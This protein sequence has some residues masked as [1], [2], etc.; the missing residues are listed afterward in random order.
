MGLFKHFKIDEFDCS[1]CGKNWVNPAL[2]KELDKVRTELGLPIKVVSGYRCP[3]H[4]KAV[5]G[6]KDSQHVLGQ[7]ADIT[8]S[9]LEKLWEILPKYFQAIGDGRAK[10]FIH[11]DRR[12][13]KV[14]RWVY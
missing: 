8:C 1:C 6:V 4:N 3:A 12:G 10:G 2:I 7:A 13:P 5:G 11:V 14:R 9:D